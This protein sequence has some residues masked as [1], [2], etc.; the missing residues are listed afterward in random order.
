MKTAIRRTLAGLVAANPLSPAASS[1]LVC[2]PAPIRP[3]HRQHRHQPGRRN[4]LQPRLQ[5][6]LRH[7]LVRRIRPLGLGP[8]R[9]RP[10][11]PQR[12][13]QSFYTYK[14]G[15]TRSS[16]PPRRRRR[17]LQPKHHRPPATT[18][19]PSSSPSTPTAPTTRSAATKTAPTGA[20]PKSPET[21]TATPPSADDPSAK[22]PADSSAPRDLTST[23]SG[24][25]Y[26][27]TNK[28]DLVV[29]ENGILTGYA[30][31]NPG[32]TGAHVGQ[33]GSGWS[34]AQW[35]NTKLAD[36]NGDGKR[37]SSR[38][39]TASI[40]AYKGNGTD[41]TYVGQIGSGWTDTQWANTKFADYNVMARPTCQGRE[42][43]ILIGFVAKR[44]RLDLCRPDRIRLDRHPVGEH[45][46]WRL[47]R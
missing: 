9:R 25:S 23:H 14:N 34:Q 6:L 27:G 2:Q 3:G 5:P 31:A 32:P 24:A 8:K 46:P 21:T 15:T 1:P 30:A 35:N 38:R 7:G 4:G 47:Q 13:R 22:V 40:I 18:T 12:L 45:P 28:A 36:Y 33:I 26:N 42:T 41:W 17:R 37:T 19:S 20:T 29:E 10:H 43:A 16:T 44:N 39:R 11:R